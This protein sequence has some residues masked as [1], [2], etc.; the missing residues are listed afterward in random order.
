MKLK[1]RMKFQAILLGVMLTISIMAVLIIASCRENR[2]DQNSFSYRVIEVQ[3]MT[4]IQW[5][6]P[7]SY[8]GGLTCN[9]DEWKGK[10][11]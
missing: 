6:N 9:W 11:R 3:E 5:G 4:C 1:S 8:K 7:I 10:A 2:I